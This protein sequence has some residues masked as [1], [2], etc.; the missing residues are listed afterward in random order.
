MKKILLIISLVFASGLFAFAQEE[1]GQANEKI[2]DKM[3]EFIQK[4]LSLSRSEA[5]RFTP[6]FL[7]YFRDWR[8][9]MREYKADKLIM[10]QKIIEL[11]LRYRPEFREIVGEQRGNEVYKHQD[12]FIHELNQIKN[13]RLNERRGPLK[14]N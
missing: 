6:V 13:E 9:T 8:T 12:I 4:R 5:E 10:Q 3:N 2:R 11:R 14:R 1:D 7:R